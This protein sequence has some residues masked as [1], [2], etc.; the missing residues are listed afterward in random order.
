[1]IKV[2]N[3][4]TR[5]QVIPLPSTVILVNQQWSPFFLS[6]GPEACPVLGV[7]SSQTR[8]KSE[9]CCECVCPWSLWWRQQ[10]Y[11]GCTEM[12]FPARTVFFC[13]IST[14]YVFHSQ[15][16]LSDTKSMFCKHCSNTHIIW[17]RKQL[18]QQTAHTWVSPPCGPPDWVAGMDDWYMEG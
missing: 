17:N 4:E 15:L 12:W 18:L 6:A 13:T 1:M 11:L 5:L 9:L 3:M 8:P 2:Q 7:L 16:I 14:A 10:H